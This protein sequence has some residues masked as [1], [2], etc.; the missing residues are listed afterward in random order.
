MDARYFS[1]FLC[2][3]EAGSVT[4]A[5]ERL[6]RSQPSVT[7][8]VQELES[9]L[10]F[11]LFRRVGRRIALTREG[12]AFEEEARRV[13]ALLRD[14]PERTL[15][16]AGAMAQ[17]MTISATSALGTGLVPHAIARWSESDHPRDIRLMLGVANAVG[18]DLSSGR[19]QIGLSSLP[20]DVPGVVCLRQFAAPVVVALPEDRAVEFPEG[21]TVPLRAVTDA[22]L[23]TM[24]DESRLQGRIQQALDAA[25]VRVTREFHANSSVAVLQLVR[26]TG[27]VAIVEPVTAFGATPPGVILRALAETVDFA[28]GFLVADG[29][30]ANR[31][32]DEFFALCEAAARDLIPLVRRIDGNVR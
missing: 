16:R 17:P 26:L 20:L 12:I 2:V 31:E 29:T 3:A 4:L 15:A 22:S 14:L 6:G 7:R 19:A 30:A 28:F 10:G 23:V 25:G 1:T 13:V 9:T 18:H 21:K 24:L 32:T 8:C 5:A 27:A 11:D